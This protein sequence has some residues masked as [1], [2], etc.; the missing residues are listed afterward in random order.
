MELLSEK[1]SLNWILY[2]LYFGIPFLAVVNV[3]ILI[4]LIQIKNR[5]K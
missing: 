4:T 2:V 5:L 3:A 1:D